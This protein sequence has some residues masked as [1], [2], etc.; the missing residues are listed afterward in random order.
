MIHPEYQM[1]SGEVEP[2][3]DVMTPIYPTTE[4]LHQQRLRRLI[5]QALAVLERH[6]S[7][8]TWLIGYPRIGPAQSGP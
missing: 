4:G 2:P 8:T 6:R 3:T 5:R 1:L 7:R